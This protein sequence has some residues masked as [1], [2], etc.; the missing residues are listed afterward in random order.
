MISEV[1]ALTGWTLD[2]ILNMKAT[3]FFSIKRNLHDIEF[4]KESKRFYEMCKVAFIPNADSQ[5]SKE[6]KDYYYEGFAKKSLN[7][8][9]VLDADDPNTNEILEKFLQGAPIG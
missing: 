1:C 8:P 4:E 3:A 6:L 7:P 9:I 5:Y 2:Q